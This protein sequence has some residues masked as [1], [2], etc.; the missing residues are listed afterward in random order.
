MDNKTDWLWHHWINECVEEQRGFDKPCKLC[1]KL[2]DEHVPQERGGRYCIG[3][4]NRFM[5]PDFVPDYEHPPAGTMYAF[6]S[7]MQF[8]P[9]AA[10]QIKQAKTG[11]LR[12]IHQQ[13]SR[14]T[15]ELI[16][17][18]VLKCWLGQDVA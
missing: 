11:T 5:P 9:Y 12:T 16:E 1:G 15:P 18:N 14:C 13:C 6:K 7:A 4:K 8:M 2:F 10:Q 3:T 17:K